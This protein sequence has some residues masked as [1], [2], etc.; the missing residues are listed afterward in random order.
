MHLEVDKYYL[1]LL[2]IP[3][4]KLFKNQLTDLHR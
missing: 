1:K 2:Q 4:K 3:V